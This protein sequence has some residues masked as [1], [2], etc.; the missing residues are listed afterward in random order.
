MQPIFLIGYMGCGKTTLARSVARATTL[1]VIDL[2][3]YIEGRF[4][5]TI[6]DI[7]AAEGEARFR[8]IEQ[9][10]LHEVADFE[11]VLIACG[12]GTPCFADNMAYMNARGTTVWL[13]AT[14]GRMHERLIKGRRKRPLLANLT[15]EQ[16]RATIEEGMA[17]RTPFYSQA[18][19]VFP[20]DLLDDRAQLTASTER[21]IEIAQLT[22]YLK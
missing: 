9:R 21:F 15:D 4:H 5:R 11:D 14:V 12:G 20:A 3:A 13:D 17:K 6:S 18:K 8:D 19:I 2:D 7:F 10:M 16:I 1:D 22:H